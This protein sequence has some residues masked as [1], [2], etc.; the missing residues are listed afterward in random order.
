MIKNS[1]ITADIHCAN[2]KQFSTID[3]DGRNTRFLECVKVLSEIYKYAR[4]KHCDRVFILGD[5]FHTR[6]KIDTVIYDYVFDFLKVNNDFRTYLV[7]GNHDQAV[8]NGSVH[9]LRPFKELPHIEVI[10][11]PKTINNI[12]FL[13]YQ[14]HLNLSILTPAEYLMG[15][16]GLAGAIVGASNY[17]IGETLTLKH[18]K[19]YKKAF[20]GHF[21]KYQILGNAYIPGSPLQHTS[22]EREDLKG[23]FYVNNTYDIKFV[24]TAAPKFKVIEVADP[25]DVTG[26]NNDDYVQFIIK[27]KKVKFF[28]FSTVSTNYKITIDLPKKFEERLEIKP[29]ESDI[30]ILENYI[31]KFKD[32][33]IS[34]GL[35]LEKMKELGKQIWNKYEKDGAE[36]ATYES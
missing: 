26:F 13:P 35:N 10:D 8:K 4:E 2:Y 18:L 16:A 11:I 3:S 36:D 22:G 23:F 33:L 27:S 21:H 6:G 31:Q 24:E 15:H 32:P 7:V 19:N 29:E 20:L 30:Q 12:L 17:T 34:Q 1:V 9:S 25:A 14:E 5:L 28:D